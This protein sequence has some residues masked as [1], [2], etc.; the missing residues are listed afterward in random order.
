MGLAIITAVLPSLLF[1]LCFVPGIV[2]LRDRPS[3]A[4][5]LVLLVLAFPVGFVLYLWLYV[6]WCLASPALLLED[7]RIVQALGRAW[8][9]SKGTFWRLLGILLLTM[10]IVGILG[11]HR[12]RPVRRDRRGD[13]AVAGA[14]RRWP[15]PRSGTTSSGP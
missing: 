14:T 3:L 15:T 9:L 5:G 12:R 2:V 7:Q 10:I 13:Q 11:E 6:K 1:L 4:T 8:R